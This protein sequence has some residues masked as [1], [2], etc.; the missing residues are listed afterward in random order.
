MRATVCETDA[1]KSVADHTP[2]GMSAD[3]LIVRRQAAHEDSEKQLDRR[4]VELTKGE[5]ALA[6]PTPQMRQTRDVGAAALGGISS[7]RQVGSEGG[8]VR[9]Q[10]ASRQPGLGPGMKQT[11][12]IH[13]GLLRW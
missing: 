13:G 1:P 5:A 8:G 12:R 7:V 3:G 2:H 11:D 9:R 10:Y 6:H 4:L